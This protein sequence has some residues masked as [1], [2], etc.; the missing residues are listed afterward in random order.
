MLRDQH[1]RVATALP[2]FASPASGWVT[3]ESLS[4]DVSLERG[5][6]GINKDPKTSV[7]W[8]DRL[9]ETNPPIS[10][11]HSKHPFMLNPCGIRPSFLRC[12]GGGLRS[13]KPV[14]ISQSSDFPPTYFLNRWSDH[15]SI[16]QYFIN[17]INL[18]DL[19]KHLLFIVHLP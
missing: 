13:L 15:Y 5:V 8:A 1:Y 19:I 18:I 3:N 9:L 2:G 17:L 11:S 14:Y 6:S 7:M 4:I 10:P 16:V 12:Q